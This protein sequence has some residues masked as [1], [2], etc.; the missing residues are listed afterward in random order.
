MVPCLA[1]D[2]YPINVSCMK[3][4]RKAV[5]QDLEKSRHIMN[6]YDSSG[7]TG[8]KGKVHCRPADTKARSRYLESHR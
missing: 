4:E 7:R 5:S 8:Q 3:E 6:V 1:Y 2:R